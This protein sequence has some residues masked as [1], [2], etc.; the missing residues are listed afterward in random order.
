MDDRDIEEPKDWDPRI[1]HDVIKNILK[2]PPPPLVGDIHF[3]ETPGGFEIW[4]SD[5]IASEHRDLVDQSADWLETVPG[6]RQDSPTNQSES[7]KT[8][9]G[10]AAVGSYLRTDAEMRPV[11]STHPS[12]SR[13]PVPC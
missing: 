6:C 10:S 3:E 13:F 8:W 2:D 12:C 1:T 9:T 5:R 7:A 4:Y 11:A